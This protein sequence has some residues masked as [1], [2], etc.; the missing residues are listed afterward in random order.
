M[1]SS[2]SRANRFVIICSLLFVSSVF[3]AGC[4]NNFVPGNPTNNTFACTTL[5]DCPPGSTRCVN[6]VCTSEDEHGCVPDGGFEWCAALQKYVQPW[7]TPCTSQN[8]NGSGPINQQPQYGSLSAADNAFGF[9]L[10]SKVLADEPDKNANMMISPASISL[11]LSMVYEGAAG[12]TQQE[13]GEVLQI[14]NI[15]PDSLNQESQSL[16]QSLSNRND[17]NL[18]IADSLWLNSAQGFQ[19]EPDYQNDMATYYNASAQTLD[20]SEE[21][22]SANAINGWVS[23]NTNGKIS[24]IVSPSELP[25]YQAALVDAVYFKGKWA[26]PFD[27]NLTQDQAFT[28]SDGSSQQVPT[29]SQDGQYWY[30][31]EDDI[32]GTPTLQAI[33]LPYGNASDPSQSMDMY[34]FLPSDM[35]GFTK[36]LDENTWNTMEAKFSYQQGT[37]LLPKFEYGYETELIPQL[38]ELGMNAA[39]SS[40][41]NFSRMSSTPLE[42]GTVKHEAY[43]ETD[44]EGSEAAAATFVGMMTGASLDSNEPKPFYMDVD[45]PFFYAIVDDNT[46]EILFMGVVN[47]PSAQ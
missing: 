47:D 15:S 27:V 31:E 7:V 25:N 13:M 9:N 44:E 6:G 14:G 45:K 46:G 20:F 24:D 19:F 4:T 21:P 11:A 36:N 18:S 35:S 30:F 22:A 23:D 37:I 5:A 38:K 8:Q 29:M 26:Q 1:I 43:I 16:I 3:L 39:F 40:S 17:V 42:I 34:V 28:T 10:F 41:A 2:F 33:K 12:T 32:I